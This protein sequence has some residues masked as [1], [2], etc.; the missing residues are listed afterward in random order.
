[1]LLVN[2]YL[3]Y[4]YCGVRFRMTPLDEAVRAGHDEVVEL[5]K[6]AG[7]IQKAAN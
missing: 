2:I 4:F 3:Y 1:M 7:A 6:K 5:L